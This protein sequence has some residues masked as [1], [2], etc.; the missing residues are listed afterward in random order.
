[1]RSSL[2]AF[3]RISQVS[4]GQGGSMQLYDPRRRL[5]QYGRFLLTKEQTKSI[6]IEGINMKGT[7]RLISLGA[8]LAVALL[9]VNGAFAQDT[10]QNAR[11]Y[12]DLLDTSDLKGAKVKNLQNEDLGAID[13][14]LIEPA[15]GR[16]RFAVVN[17]GGFLGIGGA[18]VAVPFTAFQITKEG[19]KP[20]FIVDA[21]K[22]FLEKAPRV[23]DRKYESLYRRETA[24][25][26]FTYWRVIWLP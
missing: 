14:L 4:R 6:M 12:P 26:V 18:R 15:S 9:G 13:E 5:S 10:N 23:E 21:N 11:N 2:P 16:V 7:G 25:P 17:V 22:D 24:E 19:D 8:A 1:M 20:K 3:P